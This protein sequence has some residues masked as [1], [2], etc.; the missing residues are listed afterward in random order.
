MASLNS[1]LFDAEQTCRSSLRLSIER[2]RIGSLSKCARLKVGYG[3]PSGPGEA[4]GQMQ[5][6]TRFCCFAAP[7]AVV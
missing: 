1:V 7:R 3:C 6:E 5:A 2:D 4:A